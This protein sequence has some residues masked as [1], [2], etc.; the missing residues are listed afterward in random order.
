MQRILLTSSD[1]GEGS[2]LSRHLRAGA[3]RVLQARNPEQCLRL[4]RRDPDLLLL[5]LSI[6]NAWKVLRGIKRGGGNGHRIPV[7][8]F[9]HGRNPLK[10]QKAFHLGA[11]GYLGRPLMKEELLAAVRPF[12]E[13]KGLED[14]QL[15]AVRLEQKETRRL[16][17]EKK[18]LE[19]DLGRLEEFTERLASNIP[20]SIV[21]VD[22]GK[23][24]TYVNRNFCRAMGKDPDGLLRHPLESIFPETFYGP[25]GFLEKVEEVLRD[26]RPTPRFSMGY[27]GDSYTYRVLPIASRK[28]GDGQPERQ[29]M[30]LI[31]NVSELKT[32]GERVQLSEE[33]YRI[34]FEGSPD[35]ILVTGPGGGKILELNRQAVRLLGQKRQRLKRGSLLKLYPAETRL[36]LKRRLKERDS[37]GGVLELPELIRKGPGEVHRVLAVTAGSIH[38]K[39]EQALLCVFKDITERRFL[40]DQVRQA[41][42]MSLLGQFTAGAAHEI[43]NPL[44]IISSHAQYFLSRI[45]GDRIK[46]RQLDELRATLNLIDRESRF[47]GAIIKNMLAYTHTRE[48]IKGSADLS[49]V[50]RQTLKIVEHQIK[51]SNIV[52]ECKTDADLKVPG[53]ANLLQQVLMNLIWNAQAAMPKGGRLEIGC[54]RATGGPVELRVEDNGIGIPKENIEKIFTPFF[55]TKEV[56]KGTGLGLWVVRSIVDEHQ[57]KIEVESKPNK[58]TCVTVRFPATLEKHGDDSSH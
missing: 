22:Q 53:D 36:L 6:E 24:V 32:L 26:G 50:V 30:V 33:K 43:N 25:L 37:L 10:E 15:R 31:E 23:R 21:I 28:R 49:D 38:H 58:G 27:R 39:G 18:K 19:A 51:L 42:K 29:A 20:L 12:V 14:S 13:R 45:D 11:D 40:E 44:A 4:S 8:T 1:P 57:G 47:C 35:G 9:D 7:L 52:I 17:R 2:I 3:F 48:A 5:D 54:R 16:E 41:E 56:G 55:T 34:L 46:G